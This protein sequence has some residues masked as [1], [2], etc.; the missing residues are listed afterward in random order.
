[1]SEHPIELKFE[2][3]NVFTRWPCTVCGGCTEKVPVLVEAKDTINGGD[4]RVCEQCLK[5]GEVDDELRKHA[6]QLVAHA[7][8]LR[9]LV[10]C[11]RVPTFEQW[12]AECERADME[13][14]A[15]YDRI[16]N[17]RQEA[18][19]R[20]EEEKRAKREKEK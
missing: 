18:C 16:D 3:T 7:Q 9:R 12:E 6:D 10:G 15:E 8:E 2:R 5:R 1:M 11:L 19:E 13:A 4:I 14:Q 17:A 20:Y